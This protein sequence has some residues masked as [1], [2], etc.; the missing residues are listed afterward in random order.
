MF[1]NIVKGE[2]LTLLKSF[3]NIRIERDDLMGTLL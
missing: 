1:T 2:R 3:I